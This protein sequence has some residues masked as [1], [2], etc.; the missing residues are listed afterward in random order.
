MTDYF[1]LLDQPRRPWLNPAPLKEVFLTRS[2]E[3]HPDRVH[4]ASEADRVAATQR[5]AELNAAHACLREPRDRLRH[6]LE[7]ELGRKPSDLQEMP[8]SFASLFM[9]IAGICREADGVIARQ[10]TITS[11]LLRVQC[12]E[13]VHGWIE[14]LQALQR[15]I[16]DRHNELLNELRVVDVSWASGGERK[17]LFPELERICR[18]LGFFGRWQAQ[19]QD[20][21]NRLMV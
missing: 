18:W 13:E 19:L 21:I 14:R 8:E 11:P 2:A 16:N 12:L 9:E 15:R 10:A 3:V 6:L 4:G 1:S 7:L 20:R 17:A 5:F